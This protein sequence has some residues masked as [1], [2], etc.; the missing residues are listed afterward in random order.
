M[1]KPENIAEDLHYRLDKRH[2]LRLDRKHSTD[3]EKAAS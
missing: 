1:T 3:P 2:S